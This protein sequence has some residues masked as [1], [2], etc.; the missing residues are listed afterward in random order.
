MRKI[1]DKN[2]RKHDTGRLSEQIIRD[3]LGKLDSV[4]EDLR[5][6]YFDTVGS[7]STEA[8]LRADEG[9]PTLFVAE[10][11][12]GGRGRSGKSFSCPRGDG[13][14]MS[15]LFYPRASVM[16]ATAITAYTA[17][18]AS[19]AIDRLTGVKTGIKWVNDLYLGGRKIAG[20]LTEGRASADGRL[21]YAII[22]IGI[23]LH[24]TDLG[25]LNSIATSIEAEGGSPTDR[26]ALITEIIA[27][28]YTGLDNPS[29]DTVKDEYISRS[30]IE[31]KAVTVTVGDTVRQATAIRLDRELRLLVR[32]E[33]GC[34]QWLASG[35][36]S[37]RI[38]D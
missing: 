9:I 12:T 22:G 15:L 13:I 32:Y 18:A 37:L 4:P 20:I 19:R 30:V 17:V 25:E 5:V 14:Y 2:P 35:D 7:T 27:E 11:Q 24:P 6:V 1:T 10:K 23:N 8:K 34:E 38:K 36:V 29:A 33:D 26:A 16:E 21:D 28:L 3:S 31:G